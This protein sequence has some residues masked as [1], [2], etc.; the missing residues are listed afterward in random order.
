MVCEGILMP[1]NK[2]TRFRFRKIHGGKQRLAFRGN[3]VIETK[4]FLNKRISKPRLRSFARE[5]KKTAKLY[6]RLGFVSF[7]RQEAAHS[8]YFSKLARKRY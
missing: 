4:T 7:G 8:R 1:L 2:G 6:R 5:E 3:K